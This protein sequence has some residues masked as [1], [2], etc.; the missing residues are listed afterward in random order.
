MVRSALWRDQ[1]DREQCSSSSYRA[2]KNRREEGVAQRGSSDLTK[3]NGHLIWE[4]RKLSST[5]VYH[6]EN[7]TTTRADCRDHTYAERPNP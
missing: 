1:G 7:A 3:T 2:E 5:G 6:S 4:K